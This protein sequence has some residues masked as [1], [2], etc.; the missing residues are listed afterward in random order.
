MHLRSEGTVRYLHFRARRPQGLLQVDGCI[1]FLWITHD[2]CRYLQGSFLR[3]PYCD[4]SKKIA[5]HE[6]WRYSNRD[7][8]HDAHNPHDLHM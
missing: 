2:Q 4:L 3:C 8:P 1:E 7:D 5:R 6:T